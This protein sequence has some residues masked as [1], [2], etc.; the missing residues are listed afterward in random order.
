MP[1]AVGYFSLRRWALRTPSGGLLPPLFFLLEAIHD[2]GAAIDAARTSRVLAACDTV[3]QLWARTHAMWP[4]DAVTLEVVGFDERSVD[5]ARIRLADASV[6]ARAAIAALRHEP[7]TGPPFSPPSP[8]GGG[9]G[10]TS[11]TAT[12]AASRAAFAPMALALGQ[13]LHRAFHAFAARRCGDWVACAALSNAAAASAAAPL[14]HRAFEVKGRLGS[15]AYS[16]VYAAVKR[17]TGRLYAMKCLDKRRMHAQG[18]AALLRHERDVLG[19]VR[20]PFVPALRYAFH[21]ATEVC[22]GTGARARGAGD[23]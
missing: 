7:S 17:D 13:V 15:G 6:A 16:V 12:A 23:G 9:G 2:L 19:L 10:D 3:T 1:H 22:L 14:S 21:S 4:R 11:A 20:S 8:P 18:G 5:A